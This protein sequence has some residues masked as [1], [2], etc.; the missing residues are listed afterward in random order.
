M[1]EIFKDML[2]LWDA[3]RLSSKKEAFG[4]SPFRRLR[5]FIQR[6][7]ELAVALLDHH[8]GIVVVFRNLRIQEIVLAEGRFLLTDIID[9]LFACVDFCVDLFLILF[10]GLKVVLAFRTNVSA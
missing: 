7:S 2:P 8:E 4:M 3:V 9:L 10:A 1:S 5:T 6:L